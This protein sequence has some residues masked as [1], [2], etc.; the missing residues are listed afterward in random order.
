MMNDNRMK[1]SQPKSARIINTCRILCELR[2][3]ENLS[4]AE[5]ARILELNKV[6]IGEI[7]TD[8][9]SQGIV[10]E[11][12]KLDVS[13]GRKPT[14]LEI[15]KDAKY[16]L[17][18]HIG[19]K[20]ISVALCNLIGETIKFERIPCI[21]EGLVEEF[22]ASIIKSCIRTLKLV[23]SDN[24]LGVGVTISG[25]ISVDEKIIM[26]CPYLPWENIA[27]ADV[28]ENSVGLKCVISSSVAALVAAEKVNNPKILISGQPILYLDWGDHI[29]LALISGGKIAGTNPYFGQMNVSGEKTLEDFC[30]SWAIPILKSK[31]TFSTMQNTSLTD[32]KLKNL[33]DDISESSLEYMAKAL[34]IAKQVTGAERAIFGGESSTIDLSCM[35]RIKRETTGLEIINSSLGD[36]A[37]IVASAE[38]ALD[39]FF[40]QTSLLDDVRPWL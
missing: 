8:L 10:K 5:L 19:S 13:N 23:Q 27:F 18:I 11:G 39:R 30:A 32:Y 14:T 2:M 7:V 31:Y 25:K 12:E 17:C 40:Y 6:S 9:V 34:N 3:G 20:N 16:V 29:A 15:I 28:I 24:V 36:K 33:W 35:R 38:F 26:S 4:K 1:L 22:C 37:N 21:T